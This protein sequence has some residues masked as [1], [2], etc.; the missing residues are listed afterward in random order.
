M[1]SRVLKEKINSPEHSSSSAKFSTGGRPVEVCCSTVAQ[2]SSAQHLISAHGISKLQ[3]D[4]NLS[5]NKTLLVAKHIRSCAGKRGIIEVGLKSK[6]SKVNHRLD[7]YFDVS[8]TSDYK[9]KDGTI[10]GQATDYCCDLN[11][12]IAKIQEEMN[13]Q[14][15][16]LT[17]KVGID[18]GAAF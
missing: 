10:K 1:A 15:N 5:T 13:L 11:G 8:V 14:T 9:E 18:G 12:L 17:I 16:E 4:L 2:S 6:L 7:D 3:V